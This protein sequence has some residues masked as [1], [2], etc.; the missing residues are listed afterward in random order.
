MERTKQEEWKQVRDLHLIRDERDREV[1]VKARGRAGS[2]LLTASQLLAALLLLAG[3]PAWSVLLALTFV[4]GV[5]GCFYRFSQDREW[6]RLVLGLL[7][8]G[9]AVGLI[10]WYVGGRLPLPLW[11]LAQYLVSCWVLGALSALVFVGLVLG[12]VYLVDKVG[13]MD[14]DKWEAWFSTR[15]TV[16]LLAWTVALMVLSV[17]LVGGLS[18]PLFVW[19]DLPD[20]ALASG[21][22]L[23]VFGWNTAQKLSQKRDKLVSIL[24]RRFSE[25]K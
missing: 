11:Q 6:L 10:W 17:G 7:C 25:E 18:Y 1:E 12:S 22:F 14:G 21:L 4:S 9:A 24:M 3:D 15:S 5:V 8:A 16:E 23:A 19:M 2:A 13:R 20:P